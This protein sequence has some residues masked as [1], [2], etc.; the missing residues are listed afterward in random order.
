MSMPL[1][2]FAPGTRA[3]ASGRVKVPG[4]LWEVTVVAGKRLPPTPRRGDRFVYVDVTRHAP[5]KR[6]ADRVSTSTSVYTP[7][8]ARMGTTPS[9]TSSARS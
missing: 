8:P 4:S 3:P 9:T 5:R 2:L 1:G 7:D 6:R